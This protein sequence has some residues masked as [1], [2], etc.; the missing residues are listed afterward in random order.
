METPKPLIGPIAL[1]PDEGAI[2]TAMK[3]HQEEH[4]HDSGV[5]QTNG[6]LALALMMSL[7]A[8]N[9]IPEVRLKYFKDPA[10]RTGRVKGSYRNLFERNKT[11]GD[12]IFRHPNFLRHLRHFLFGAELP[13][14]V[15]DAFSS[16]ALAHGHVGPSDALELVHWAEI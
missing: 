13:D 7:L 9:A 4:F 15:I 3:L 11:V 16:K 6:E 14:K 10:Y 2:H 12:D 8:R 5:A 1:T